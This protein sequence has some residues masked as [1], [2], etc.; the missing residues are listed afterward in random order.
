[1]HGAHPLRERETSVGAG[2]SGTFATGDPATLRSRV[3]QTASANSAP[4]DPAELARATAVLLTMAPAVA[5]WVSARLGLQGNNEVGLTY[6]GRAAGFDARHA[7]VDDA[8]ALSVG[9]GASW[10]G[11]APSDQPS[12]SNVTLDWRSAGVDVPILVGWRS[13]AG[14]VSLW[15]GARAGFERVAGHGVLYTSADQSSSGNL[16]LARVYGGGVVGLG[17]G[18]RHLHGTLEL[19]A[20]YQNVS[21]SVGAFDVRVRGVTLAP[22]AGLVATF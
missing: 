1:L 16:D 19:D 10:I 12:A 20:T 22:A 18:F 15:A 17:F 14:V 6:S 7:F 21:G 2:F 4:G 3:A 5:P 8:W 9:L 13:T 11:T